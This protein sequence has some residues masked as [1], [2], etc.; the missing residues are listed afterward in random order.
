MTRPVQLTLPGIPVEPTHED[1]RALVTHRLL[2]FAERQRERE[3]RR[4]HRR[5]M[6]LKAEYRRRNGRTP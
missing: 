2:G 6:A 4:A 1:I 5:D 3:R